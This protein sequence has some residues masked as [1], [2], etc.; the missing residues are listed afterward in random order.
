[1]PGKIQRWT[2][3]VNAKRVLK[4]QV[5]EELRGMSQRELERVSHLSPLRAH[6]APW[7]LPVWQTKRQLSASV[8]QS[9]SEWASGHRIHARARAAVGRLTKQF[10]TFSQSLYLLQCSATAS[11]SSEAV[12]VTTSMG[13]MF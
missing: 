10:I 4:G 9:W 7:R 5:I 2:D 3:T 6:Y 13:Q 11:S 12:F 8:A 1:M